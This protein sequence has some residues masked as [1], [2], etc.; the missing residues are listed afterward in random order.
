MEPGPF[1]GSVWVETG[2]LLAGPYPGP[3]VDALA[4]AGVDVVFD[5]TAPDEGL[6]PYAA[7]L[8]PGTRLRRRPV[9]D[10]TTPSAGA[11]RETLDLLE[12]ELEAGSTVYVH[13]QGGIGRTGTLLGCLLV[14]RGQSPE[15]ALAALKAIGK[16]PER[17][18]QVELVRT[19]TAAS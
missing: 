5:L 13:C 17:A 11:M 10:F 4:E 14:Q 9:A 19:W 2:R 16:H 18:E 6:E 12:R 1:A 8:R 3:H 7:R 15:E